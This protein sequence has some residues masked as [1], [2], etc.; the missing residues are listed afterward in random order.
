MV[1][2]NGKINSNFGKEN[3]LKKYQFLL[4]SVLLLTLYA[5]SQKNETLSDEDFY[6]TLES[7][8]SSSAA[9]CTAQSQA[10]EDITLPGDR[11]TGAEDY[12]V[13]IIEYCDYQSEGCGIF[14]GTI[15]KLRDEFPDD[16]RVIFRHFPVAELDKDTLAAQAAEAAGA[17]GK[18][19]EMNHQLFAAQEEWKGLSPGEFREWLAAAASDLGLDSTQFM[20]DLTSDDVVGSVERAA[21]AAKDAGLATPPAV[22]IDGY[23]LTSQFYGYDPLQTLLANYSIPLGKLAK[24]QFSECPPMTID[25]D[26]QYTATL[27]TEV[28]DIVLAL[29]PD[30]APFAVNNFIFL[31]Q[32]NFYDNVTF[33]RVIEG[34]MAQGGDPSG[35]GKGGPGYYFSIETSPD[36]TFD[37]AGLLAMANAGPT[38]NGCQFFITYDAAEHLNGQ[39]TIFGEVLEGMD[40]VKAL[41]PR[42]PQ[43]DPFGPPGTKILDVTIEEK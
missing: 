9:V 12:S 43:A 2:L 4:L 14:S 16:L 6:A 5:C 28:G 40:I 24:V 31:A 11:I 20:T 27:H 29:Y 10:V 36:V 3:Q 37:R 17:Q 41:K 21:K 33:H 42:D 35:T 15:N 7:G 32:H 23:A 30:I 22:L 8:P 18:F 25:P 26:K 13:T 19:W 1:R 39:Y 34:F 38:A